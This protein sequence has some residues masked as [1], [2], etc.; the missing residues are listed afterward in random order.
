MEELAILRLDLLGSKFFNLAII[1]F[2]MS[3]D[4]GDVETI[5]GVRARD[6][7]CDWFLLEHQD[8]LWRSC[9]VPGPTQGPLCLEWV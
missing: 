2:L 9:C 3:S 5:A 6:D 4:P 8:D 1:L 7:P